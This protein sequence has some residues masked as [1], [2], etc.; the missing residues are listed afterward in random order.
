MRP[1]INIYILLSVIAIEIIAM[2]M[3][4]I[5]WWAAV[6]TAIPFLLLPLDSD[7]E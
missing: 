2:S 7:R 3:G 4:I 6:V 5:P 1:N